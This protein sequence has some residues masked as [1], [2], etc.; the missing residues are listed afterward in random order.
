[1]DG[2]SESA[3]AWI[4]TMG[5]SGDLGRRFILDPAFRRRLTGAGFRR[6]LD[7][8]CG[9][10]RMCRLLAE[11][12]VQAI[13][14]DP[15]AA[16]LDEARRRDPAGDYRIASAE[17]LP[18][19]DGDFDLVISCLTMI[20][21]PDFRAA[22]GQMARVL[23]PG[24]VLL[25]ANL[26]PLQTAAMG[27]GWR[28]EDGGGPEDG[29]VFALDRYLEEWPEWV[30]WRGIRIVNWHRPL[31]AYIQAYLAAGLTLVS[32]E[33]LRPAEG[34]PEEAARLYDRAPWF[35]LMEWRKA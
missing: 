26:T 7:V 14:I 3:A 5:E 17:A 25:V 2:W 18:F 13:G 34:Y 35:D 10:G 20:D 12:G 30:E 11:L 22:I 32:Y 16:L 6:A 4:A 28:A 8:G 29:M 27:R 9:E 33:D 15:T 1:V 23:A 19:A 24:G 21:I 31:S